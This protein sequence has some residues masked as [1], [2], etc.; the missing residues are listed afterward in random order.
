MTIKNSK[1]TNQRGD[2]SVESTDLLA[3]CERRAIEIYYAAPPEK[4]AGECRAELV[5]EFGESVV[6]QMLSNGIGN[7][8]SAN[9]EARNR[10]LTEPDNQKE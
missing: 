4:L 6:A 10:D 9:V 2:S 3:D 1:T 8:G 7:N 5:A